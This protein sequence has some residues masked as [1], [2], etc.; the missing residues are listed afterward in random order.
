MTEA[1]NRLRNAVGDDP[2]LTPFVGAGVS[3]FAT[4]GAESASW[5]GLLLSGIEICRRVFS[6]LPPGWAARMRGQLDNA[7]VFTY[8]AVAD[9]I[10]RRLHEVWEG[11]EFDA[12]IQGTVG[13]LQYT[14]EGE[15][16]IIALR[17]LAMSGPDSSQ[18]GVILTTNYDTLIEDLGEPDQQWKPVTWTAGQWPSAATKSKV[19]LHLHGVATDTRSIIISSA[20]YQRLE[21][22][23]NKL[24]GEAY[25]V[26]RRLVFIGCGDGL[27]DPD[28]ARLMKKMI[29]L[30]PEEGTEHFILVRGDQLR[31]LLERPLSPRIRPVAYGSSFADLPVF[32]EKLTAGD[33]IDISQDPEFYEQDDASVE[34]PEQTVATTT[35]SEQ[36]PA[37]AAGDSAGAAEDSTDRARATLQELAGP[38][39]QLLDDALT[40]LQH[41]VYAMEQV[42]RRGAVPDGADDWKDFS[43]REAV[44]QRLAASLTVPVADLECCSEQVAHEVTAVEADVR[45]LSAQQ[46]FA[47]HALLLAPLAETVSELEK[48]S[49]ELL[50]SMRETRTDMRARAEVWPYYQTL[51]ETLSHAYELIEQ[52]NFSAFLIE[53]ELER[54][55]TT[56]ESEGTAAEGGEGAAEARQP[57]PEG[58]SAA[59]RRPSRRQ[60]DSGAAT[61]GQI[62][63]IGDGVIDVPVVGRAVA[64]Q[65]GGAGEEYSGT[66]PVPSRN[67]HPDRVAAVFVRG[68]SMT[69]DNIREGDYVIIDRELAPKDKDI[70]VVRTGG[71]GDSRA[72]VKRIRLTPEGETLRLESSNPNSAEAKVD[73]G[74][75]PEREGT[76]IGIYRPLK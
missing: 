40:H 41:A 66:V 6:P 33:E 54:L 24:L 50:G 30:I 61:L 62:R 29:H 47:R 57:A 43:V 65:A 37:G 72:M 25:F 7:D 51:G 28:I 32:L 44:H 56:A 34:T 15:R 59:G 3:M 49:G 55:Q 9:E 39:Q 68:D 31:Q 75:N 60:P 63:A 10:S 21:T 35:V 45:R 8:L 13:A 20:D 74:D 4:N 1:L 26:S 69:G 19:V 67:L 14:Q 16:L 12:W 11:R 46:R 64:G 17:K 48:L 38:A 22:D 52:A 2:P 23:L 36:R 53:Q 27:S 5:H 58:V 76:V 71:E 73:L 18:R 70:V 42:K